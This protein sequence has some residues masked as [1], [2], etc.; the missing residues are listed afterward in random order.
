MNTSKQINVM[1]GLL[2]VIFVV[3]AGY[4]L[5]ETSRQDVEADEITERN[6]ER[7]A[8]LFVRNCRTCH[9]LEGEGGIGFALN[10]PAFLVLGEDNV[11]GAPATPEGEAEGIRTFLRETIAC[12]R[13]GTFMPKWALEFGGSLSATQVEQL[14]TLITGDP[15][16]RRD[17][18]ELVREEGLHADEQQFGPV[19]EQRLGRHPTA[20]EIVA[21]SQ[22]ETP[23]DAA[24]LSLTQ[25]ACGQY[26]SELKIDRRSRTDPRVAAPP[27]DP[28]G[29]GGDAAPTATAAPLTPEQRGE[30]LATL[31]GCIGRHSIDGSVL[32]G[33]TWLGLLGRTEEFDDGTSIVADEAYIRDSIIDPDARIVAGFVEGVMPQTFVDDL[34]DEDIEALI[35]YI[36]TLR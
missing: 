11:Y 9:G 10:N 1:I 6:A 7:G 26:T 24:T 23:A 34:S 4:L 14:V 16:G 31:H 5:N 29:D 3:V 13:V 17:Y 25:N 27:P 12:G 22:A 19:L 36:A 8:R 21:E 35:A 32:A 33:P 18:W 28:G 15:A 30:Q 2:F 20:A